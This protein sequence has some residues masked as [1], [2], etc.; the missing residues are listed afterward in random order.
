MGAL[1]EGD[2]IQEEGVYIYRVKIMENK[3]FTVEKIKNHVEYNRVAQAYM[4][5]DEIEEE[6][7][8]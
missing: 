1:V 2:V 5:M 4:E 8:E 3:E 6:N 7:E